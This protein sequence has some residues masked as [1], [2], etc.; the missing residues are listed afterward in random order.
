MRRDKATYNLQDIRDKIDRYEA[1]EAARL[2]RIT[3]NAAAIRALSR[4]ETRAIRRQ[5]VIDD[6]VALVAEV[7]SWTNKDLLCPASQQEAS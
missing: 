2:D 5:Q 4:S 6:F 3:D 1:A 7:D